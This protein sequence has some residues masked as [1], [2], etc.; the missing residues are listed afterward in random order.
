MMD[1][2]D[3]VIAVPMLGR[4]HHVAPLLDSIRETAPG[5][6]VM[7]VVTHGDDSVWSTVLR[8]WA[9]GRGSGRYRENVTVGAISMPWSGRGDYAKKINQVIARTR[10][11]LIFTGAS[12]LRFHAGWL[13]A[14][15]G[16]LAPGI[17]VVGTN[18]LG[19]PRVVSG[20]HA[21][22]MLV[23][24]DYVQRLGTIDERGKFFH[25]GYPHEFV[26]DEAVETAKRRHAWA[27][28]LDAHV[29]HLH[30]DW[31]K[32]ER[33]RMYDQAPARARVGRRV[34]EA[35]RRLWTT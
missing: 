21:T 29:E 34:F 28:A 11:P 15:I 18:D 19:S 31:G 5:A 2:S 26:D 1:A 32:G 14:A 4:P 30:P 13:E 25:E 12:D 3:L 27:M 9:R 7:F 17:G 6:R 10:E 22:H 20:E 16:K 8:C 33:D 23:T 35:R 24:R